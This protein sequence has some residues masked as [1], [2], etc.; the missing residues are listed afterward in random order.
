M[1]QTPYNLTAARGA[2]Y[3]LRCCVCHGDRTQHRLSPMFFCVHLLCNWPAVRP[4]HAAL[5]D[6]QLDEMLQCAHHVAKFSTTSTCQCQRQR[7]APPHEHCATTS[8][9]PMA[10]LLTSV[11]LFPCAS[12]PALKFLNDSIRTIID[13]SLHYSFVPISHE[14]SYAASCHLACCKACTCCLSD[15][16]SIAMLQHAHHVAKFSTCSTC[17]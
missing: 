4:P 7:N 12:M 13:H 9:C 3:H 1:L 2:L 8:M 14:Q 6:H 10:P 15:H 5:S 16:K 17:P 11:V